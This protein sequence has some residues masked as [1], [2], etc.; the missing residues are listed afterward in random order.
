MC[1]VTVTVSVKDTKQAKSKSSVS[2]DTTTT[3]DTSEVAQDL[4]PERL[5]SL[6]HVSPCLHISTM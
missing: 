2:M 6:H 1:L 3:E 4:T 5:V